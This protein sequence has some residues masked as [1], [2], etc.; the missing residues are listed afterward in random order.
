MLKNYNKNFFQFKIKKKK[1]LGFLA[2]Q[3]SSFYSSESFCKICKNTGQKN[4]MF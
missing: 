3:C 4:F 2:L 1:L